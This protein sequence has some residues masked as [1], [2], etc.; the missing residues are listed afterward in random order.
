M[1]TG[2]LLS[3]KG[4]GSNLLH[5]SYCHEIA[6][7]YGPVSI[8]TLCKNL[9]QALSDDP[10]IKEIIYL[11]KYHKK[12]VDI[13]RLA[14]FLKKLSLDTI[15]IYYPSFR[16]IFSSKIAGIKNIK[17]YSIYK[18]K[19]LHLVYAAKKFTEKLL[20]IQNCPTETILYVDPIKKEGSKNEISKNKKNIILG[21]G[22]SGPTTRWG[23]KNFIGLIKRL[24]KDNDY[25]FYLL[26]GP[27][28]EIISDEILSQV[29]K[30]SCQSLNNK[31]I[32]E[33][34]PLISVCDIYI[35]NDS[36]G[37]HVS[38]QSSIPSYII[39]L[40]TPKAYTDYSKNQYR[41][42]PNDLNENYITHDSNISAE[43]ITVDMVLNKI[44]NFI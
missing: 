43:S 32:S 31:S 8:I 28:E 12:L 3:Y 16:Y 36:F 6:K 25:F 21:V 39:M 2:I 15:F 22:S 30:G 10:L 13:F 42:L 26:C 19:N 33:V 40:D 9:E 23:S 4:L 24:N 1:K 17:S 11:D 34:I 14:N 35:G 29:E 44:K 18:K 38:C 7:K 27:G 20:D 37:H 41:I 5:L